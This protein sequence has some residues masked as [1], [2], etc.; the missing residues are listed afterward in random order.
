MVNFSVIRKRGQKFAEHATNAAAGNANTARLTGRTCW[1]AAIECARQSG[2]ISGRAANDLNE[3]ANGGNA[4]GFAPVGGGGQ[5]I[6]SRDEFQ[7]I[8]PGCFIAFYGTNLGGGTGRVL[9]HVMVSLGDGRAAGS[10][11]T[12]VDGRGD[13]HSIN[14]DLRMFWKNGLAE[15]NMDDG[16]NFEIRVLDLDSVEAA[17]CLIM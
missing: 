17:R 4:D 3:R 10:N 12:M 15:F 11:N 1:S 2:A 8:P 14:V 5:I 7:Q 6:S 16:R 9:S 13:W